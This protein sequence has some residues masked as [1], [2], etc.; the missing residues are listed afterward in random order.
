MI[1]RFDLTLGNFGVTEAQLVQL[2]R[3]NGWAAARRMARHKPGT[4][5]LYYSK[6]RPCLMDHAF[7]RNMSLGVM[8]KDGGISQLESEAPPGS[9]FQVASNFHAFEQTMP[10]SS[11]ESVMLS[12]YFDDHTQGPAAVLPTSL[13]LVTRRYLFRGGEYTDAKLLSG[14]WPLDML[15]KLHSRGVR[16]TV[17]GWADITNAN[18]PN[19]ASEAF[20]LVNCV[21]AVVVKNALITRDSLGR[22]ASGFNQRIHQ[23]LTSTLDTTF[24]NSRVWM[25]IFLMAAY[26]N[27]LSAARDLQATNVHLTLIGGGVL[28]NPISSIFAA[29]AVAFNS[30][31][32][33][34]SPWLPGFFVVMPPLDSSNEKS[35]EAYRCQAIVNRFLQNRINLTECLK[36]IA[37]H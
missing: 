9:V 15:Q 11:P 14:R 27:T 7:P 8:Y 16:I 20:D 1:A 23:V 21:G 25:N 33:E 34:D 31:S 19:F 12:S 26:I 10:D 22:E 28:E 18:E 2:G 13:D 24:Y 3:T 6:C 17:G 32:F 35:R 30:V 36:Q 4:T 5:Q 37:A 29:M